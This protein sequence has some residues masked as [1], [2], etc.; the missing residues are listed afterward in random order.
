MPGKHRGMT[1]IELMI[2]LVIIAVLVSVAVPSYRQYVLRSHRVEATS[3]LLS[4]A[5]KQEKFYLACN[6]YT[7]NL[8]AAVDEESCADRGLGLPDGDGD[9]DD[10]QTE[11]GWYTISVEANN[12]TF[13]LTADA[14]GSQAADGECAQFTLDQNGARSATKDKCWD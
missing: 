7:E 2:T 4:I 12:L 6:T 1:L 9:V 10:L 3:A 11:N 13:S 14:I 5:A 8:T